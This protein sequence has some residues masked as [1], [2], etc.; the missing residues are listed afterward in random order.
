MRPDLR[1]LIGAARPL[2]EDA[3]SATIASIRDICKNPQGFDARRTFLST[4]A[5]VNSSMARYKMDR[6]KLERDLS[7]K[8][9]DKEKSW[10][11][12]I[13]DLVKYAAPVVG[14]L[15]MPLISAVLLPIAAAIVATVT[16]L[17]GGFVAFVGAALSVIVSN[18]VTLIAA[19]I[20]TAGATATLLY[21]Y[22]KYTETAPLSPDSVA[23]FESERRALG[24]PARKP[25]ASPIGAPTLKPR[26]NFSK[27]YARVQ[28]WREKLGLD[29]LEDK[30]GLPRGLLTSLMA[31]E[32]QGDPNARSHAGASGLFQFMPATAK[33]FN[34]D[35]LNPQQSA[36]AAAKY[37][38]YL[39]KR[40]GNWGD[41]LRAYNA[42]E[43]NMSKHRKGMRSAITSKETQEYAPK[44]NHHWKE[45]F[46]SSTMQEEQ[47]AQQFQPTYASA[48]FISPTTGRLTSPFGWRIH[49]ITR[50]RKFH[51]GV[52]IAAPVGTPVYASEAGKVIVSRAAGGAGNMITL[53][54]GRAITRYMHNSRLLVGVGTSVGKGQQIAEMGSTGAS[55]GSHLHFEVWPGKKEPGDPAAV[56]A[57]IPAGTGKRATLTATAEYQGRNNTAVASAGVKPTRNNEFYKT[58][59]G[60]I[61]TG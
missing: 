51:G 3:P 43:G 38:A 47:P 58:K 34:I 11:G 32:S 61:A 39:H 23:L 20:L 37:L 48:G 50:N 36:N 2:I 33:G 35:P 31:Q 30:H 1:L 60:I 40:F 46:G 4:Y 25:A 42:G 56:I 54:H 45:M 28:V 22:H 14:P 24:E 13:I 18:P 21:R 27:V 5:K 9:N 10:A 17:F 55:T 6:C 52:D 16:T 7:K 26:G 29:A 49:P 41:A 12:T 57:E 53:D 15:L 44:I 8:L 19:G 59:A